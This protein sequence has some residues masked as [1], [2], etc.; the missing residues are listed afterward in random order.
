MKAQ[1]FLNLPPQQ[2]L[3][4]IDRG[5]RIVVFQYVISVVILTFR[6]NAPLQYIGPGESA[7]VKSLPWTVLSFFLGWWGIPF[8]FIY[9]PMVLYRN[10]HGGTD[11]TPKLLAQLRP[12]PVANLQFDKAVATTPEP[13]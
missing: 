2:I 12:A 6:R 1:E 5:A 3:D 8:G 7:A 9:T 13:A 10:L 4:E 11:V